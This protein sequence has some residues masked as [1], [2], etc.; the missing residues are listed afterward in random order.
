MK[1]RQAGSTQEASAEKSEVSVRTGRR[2]DK[3]ENTGKK[4]RQW[5]TRKYPFTDSFVDA[6]C[7]STGQWQL[8]TD[9]RG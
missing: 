6:I 4:E 8:K 7:F 2:I 1:S 3:S 5:R 9:P